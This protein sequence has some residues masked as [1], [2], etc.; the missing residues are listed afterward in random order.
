VKIIR[1]SIKNLGANITKNGVNF[2]IFSQTAA[3]MD[4]LLFDNNGIEFL[5]SFTLFKDDDI[6][7]GE[8][9]GANSTHTYG[10]IADGEYAPQSG[11]RF[12]NHK[13]LLDPYSLELT[14]PIKLCNEMMEFGADTKDLMPKTRIIKPK[15]FN[16]NIFKVADEDRVIYELNIKGF[17]AL[18]QKIVPELRGTFL[19]LAAKESIEYIKS[20]GVNCVELMPCAA[21]VDERHLIQAGL[22][23]YW[24][25]NPICN[26]A[27]DPKLAPGGWS[28]VQTA[29]RALNDA[30]IEVIL[31]V[32]FNHSGESDEYGPTISMRGLD[33]Q[34]YYRLLDDK[35]KYA[36]DAG[37]GNVLKAD[38]EITQ[39][40]II[41]S[42]RAWV[43]FGGISGFR[44]DLAP[45]MLR[46]WHGVDFNSSLLQKIKSDSNLKDLTL[47]AEPWD[48]GYGGYQLGNFPNEWDEW[49]DKYRDIM[50]AFWRGDAVSLG[51]FAQCLCGSQNIFWRKQKPKS[52]N[53]ITA[54]DGFTL[55]DLV[56]YGN[57]NNYANGEN[58]ND[59][60]NH[61]ISCNHG[62]EGETD[63]ISI[64]NLRKKHQKNLLQSLFLS[65]GTPMIYMGSEFGK[66][67][68]GNNNAYCQDNEISWLDWED[69]D[70]ELFEFTKNL[71]AARKENAPIKAL[72]FLDG[73]TQDGIY[74][75]IIWQLPDGSSLAPH[76][77]DDKNG[78]ALVA[79]L[80]QN[81]QRVLIAFN[82]GNDCEITLPTPRDYFEWD[83]VTN[84]AS[85]ISKIKDGK[86]ISYGFSVLLLNE[87]PCDKKH[88][89]INET[90]DKMCDTLGIA[91]SWWDIS[92]QETPAPKASIIKILSAI[93][94]DCE[95][96][97]AARNALRDY[98]DKFILRPLPFY[99]SFSGDE[100]QEVELFTNL[101]KDFGLVI[102][103]ENNHQLQFDFNG[104]YIDATTPDGRKIKRAKIALPPLA[105]GRYELRRNDYPDDICRLTIAPNSCYLPETNILKGVS[106]QIYSLKR[107]EDSEFGDFT[108]LKETLDTIGKQGFQILAIN[109]LHTLFAND[110]SKKSPY[111]PS[112]RRFLE[113]LYIDTKTATKSKDDYIDYQ[114]IWAKKIKVL[115]AEFNNFI[116]TEEYETFCKSKGK[117]LD[118]FA[119]FETL[120]EKFTPLP[121]YEWEDGFK[122][123]D[124]NTLNHFAN[125]NSKRI[126][127][128]KYLQFRCNKELA[129][130]TNNNA[131]IARDL[132]IGSAPMGCENWCE[133]ELTA[134]GVSIGAPPDPLG[135]QGQVWGLPPKNP[136][137]MIEDGFRNIATLFRA[138]MEYAG[139]LR[140]DHALGLSRQF[141]IPSGMNGC[142]GT[143]VKFPFRHLLNELKL[144]SNRA[145][146][147]IIAEDLGTV[148]NGF[149]EAMEDATALSYKV[150]PFEKSYDGFKSPSEYPFLSLA[151]AATHDLPPIKGWWEAIDLKERFAL[152]LYD[153]TEFE[154]AMDARESEK[155]ALISTLKNQALLDMNFET[156]HISPQI[157]AAIHGFL[158][159][160]NSLLKVIQLED[161]AGETIPINLPGT[162]KERRNWQKYIKPT[163]KEIFSDKNEWSKTILSA[164]P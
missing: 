158:G 39:N 130:A 15:P 47:I 127:F 101:P 54:H 35:S 85:T 61:N 83:V 144:E 21:W 156:T 65:R 5:Q 14:A 123:R 72:E 36:N 23:N 55:R 68:N 147:L 38:N 105:I 109:P 66:T 69:F 103:D 91:K 3:S 119:I 63:N 53:F 100:V 22:K 146:C 20:L 112:D 60:H 131:K 136:L 163:L 45:T 164:L 10:I 126:E 37:T 122:N 33:N 34:N 138:N 114:T 52:I 58:N 12:D 134:Q 81:G 89:V 82:R 157:M 28:D 129:A 99:A 135:P 44:F 93:G 118:D 142:D 137:A 161:L 75:D 2:A 154:T 25:Y 70:E 50:R 42:L 87:T 143:Y 88:P 67:Q 30:G 79:T 110:R 74:P 9:I 71:I 40:L 56:S 150:I 92:G 32:V 11:N 13:L 106:A 73:H 108:T 111:Y 26:M 95:T 115:E 84:S 117:A 120:T 29:V 6:F 140:I 8:I 4:I 16:G 139:A 80:Y 125:K 116:P 46:N 160:T 113:P 78:K 141:W 159:K 48:I 17:S 90:L 121:W 86:I 155:I 51:E 102:I 124:K 97:Y 104:E 128:F 98:V 149:R 76:D 145:K 49:N 151:C 132:A 162:D 133:Q 24:G 31:D 96:E 94:M 57:K 18:N 107:S 148:P 153:K 7:H 152:G 41:D 77:W 27:P 64:L 19:G 43:K 62:A 59:G 1:G